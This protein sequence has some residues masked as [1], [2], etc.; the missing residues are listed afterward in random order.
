MLPL[1]GASYTRILPPA[2]RQTAR[3][4]VQQRACRPAPHAAA[5]WHATRRRSEQMYRH[6]PAKKS[7]VSCCTTGGRCDFG[8]RWAFFCLIWYQV[9]WLFSIFGVIHKRTR[10]PVLVSSDLRVV[11][12]TRDIRR[13]HLG[14]FFFLGHFM[15]KT[16]NRIIEKIIHRSVPNSAKTKPW[17]RFTGRS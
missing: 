6:G 12:E 5:G 1:E 11:D 3:R 14:L 4:A 15:D 7:S 8:Q 10:A 13:S 17:Y 2:N 9:G 16:T